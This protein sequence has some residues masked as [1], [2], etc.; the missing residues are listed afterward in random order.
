MLAVQCSILYVTLSGGIKIKK[1]SLLVNRVWMC[2]QRNGYRLQMYLF[3]NFNSTV[4]E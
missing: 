2:A 3:L 1:N 4:R